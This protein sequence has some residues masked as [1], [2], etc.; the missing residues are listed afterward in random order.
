MKINIE[1]VLFVLAYALPVA[2]ELLGRAVR[3]NVTA[4]ML[5]F[6]I[7]F[8]AFAGLIISV[9]VVDKDNFARACDVLLIIPVLIRT[10]WLGA[11]MDTRA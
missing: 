6:V 11:S 8:Y 5:L 7:D 3:W 9:G 10:M 1:L 2:V 4:R